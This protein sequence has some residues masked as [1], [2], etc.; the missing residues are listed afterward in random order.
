MALKIGIATSRC[1]QN[2]SPFLFTRLRPGE[3][4]AEACLDEAAG[5]LGSL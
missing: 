4:H 5:I 2:G 3:C 1:D